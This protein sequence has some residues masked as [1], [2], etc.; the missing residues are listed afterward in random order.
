MV[1]PVRATRAP[2]SRTRSAE[3]QVT[4]KAENGVNHWQ[5]IDCPAFHRERDAKACIAQHAGNRTRH[6]RDPT[7]RVD[8]GNVLA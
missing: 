5:S 1:L 2:V 7:L 3:A 8:N 6:A 4:P